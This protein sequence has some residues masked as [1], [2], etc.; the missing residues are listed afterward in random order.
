MSVQPRGCGAGAK[1]MDIDEAAREWH[2]KLRRL[3][4]YWRSIH[5]PAGLPGRQHLDPLAISDLLPGIW[6]LD[7]QRAPFRLRYRLVGTRIVEAVGR[8]LTGQ[9]LDEAHPHILKDPNY[10]SRFQEVVETGVPSRRRGAARLWRHE[11]YREIENAIFPLATDGH[12][13][14]VLM[15]LTVLYRSDGKA[16]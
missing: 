2:P 15:V 8:E 11:D 9:W 5:P 7:V 13:V 14:D 4:Q 16:V 12:N 3:L 6:L 10:P 1:A